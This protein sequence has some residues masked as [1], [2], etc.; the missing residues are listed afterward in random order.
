MDNN[1]YHKVNGTISFS[2]SSIYQVENTRER[3]A[4]LKMKNQYSNTKDK[5]VVNTCL[6]KIIS[7]LWL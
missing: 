4:K 2:I 3:L 1:I 5:A 6:Q 7:S